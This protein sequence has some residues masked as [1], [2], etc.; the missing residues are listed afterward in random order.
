MFERINVLWFAN[1]LDFV[2]SIL[3]IPALIAHCFKIILS[4]VDILWPYLF[5]NKQMNE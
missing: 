5:Y 2:E 1:P 4:F 3:I